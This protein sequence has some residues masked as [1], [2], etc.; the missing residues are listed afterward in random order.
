MSLLSENALFLWDWRW[1]TTALVFLLSYHVVRFYRK[2][3]QHPK[4]PFP[5]P[6]VGNLLSFRSETPLYRRAEEWSRT[7]GDPFTL[8]MGEKPMVMLNSYEVTKEALVDKRHE[9]AGRSS[10]KFGEMR[11]QG[12]H[13]I[14]FEDYNPTWK[15]LRKLALTAARKY[16]VSDSL[17]SLCTEVVDAYV[18]SLEQGPNTVD[19][20]EPFMFIFFNIIGTSVFGTKFEKDGPELARIKQLK[21][22]I[23]NVAPNGL[24]SDIVPWLGIL[25]RKRENMTRNLFTE[26][27]QLLNGLYQRAVESYVPG[28][29]Q[30][31]THSMLAAREEALE[32]EKSD[33]QYLTEA[34]MV[35]V[36]LDIFGAANDTSIGELQWLC[37]TMTR[38]PD[39]QA[40]IQQEIEGCLGKTPPTMH[41]RDKLPYTV[42]CLYE[43]LRFYPVAPMGLP[44]KTSC[45]TEAGGKFVPKG[46]GLFYNIYGVN[47]DPTLWKDPDVFR[48]E[49]FLD[50]VTG[51]LNLEGMPALLTFGMGP[52]TCPGEK[53]AHMDMF[54]VL[55]RLMQR[56]S[57]SALVGKSSTD[58]K[59]HG[60]NLFL[61]PAVQDIVL[62]RRH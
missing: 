32:Q 26:F 44:H 46:T 2:V 50:S 37:L 17:Q 48:P 47:H 14:V 21:Q 18:D 4:G 3:F 8:W 58:I 10:T 55:V 35:Q 54:Y 15:A 62:T 60:S 23:A 7:Y 12:S 22:A 51:K 38:K 52:R 43:T 11:L 31:F 25:Y 61:F 28:S 41:D 34:N 1:L 45:D 57:C 39:I 33:A 40:R 30:N 16:A 56:L 49:R 24:P 53:L 29:A 19:S 42:A 36:L 9:F 27:L 20:K 59:R 6:L 5:L 13:D